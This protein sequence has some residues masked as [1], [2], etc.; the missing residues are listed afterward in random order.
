MS[1]QKQPIFLL[2]G[3]EAEVSCLSITSKLCFFDMRKGEELEP[4]DWFFGGAKPSLF[5]FIFVL[6]STQ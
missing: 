2:N 3:A 1:S 5:L 4:F 6:F